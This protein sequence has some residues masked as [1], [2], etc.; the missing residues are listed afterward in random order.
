M[1]LMWQRLL[2][3]RNAGS[4]REDRLGIK[5]NKSKNKKIL[6][7]VEGVGDN[8][9]FFVVDPVNN[10]VEYDNQTPNKHIATNRR[11]TRI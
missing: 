6:A 4:C 7:T 11:K 10:T 9:F 2:C 5:Q 1:L 3:A 8:E